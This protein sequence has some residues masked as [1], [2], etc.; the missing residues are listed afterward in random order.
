MDKLK[1]LGMLFPSHSRRYTML[2]EM[3]HLAS[4][5]SSKGEQWRQHRSYHYW[6][7]K[8]RVRSSTSLLREHECLRDLSSPTNTQ[9]SSAKGD[10][11][12]QGVGM[13]GDRFGKNLSR[14]EQEKYSDGIRVCFVCCGSAAPR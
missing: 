1:G 7:H 14:E 9:N 13:A 4:K 11:L 5:M 10:Y 6:I 12:D 3:P 8:Q 2:I